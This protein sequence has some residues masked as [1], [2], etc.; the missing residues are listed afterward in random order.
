MKRFLE[1]LMEDNWTT[2]YSKGDHVHTYRDGKVHYGIVHQADP[3][4]AHVHWENGTTSVHR[5]Y[6]GA[7]KG[8]PHSAIRDRKEGELRHN[9]R[10]P[11]VFNHPERITNDEHRQQE[12]DFKYD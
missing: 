5:Q 8:L 1:Y 2:R 6:D 7:D 9:L 4:E 3:Q 11:P 10:F 12:G